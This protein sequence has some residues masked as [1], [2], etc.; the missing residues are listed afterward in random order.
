MEKKYV[1]AKVLTGTILQIQIFKRS[2]IISW[3]KLI[4]VYFEYV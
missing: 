4:P 1:Q 3:I 2:L